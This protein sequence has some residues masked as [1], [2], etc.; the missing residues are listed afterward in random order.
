M[1]KVLWTVQAK[2]RVCH[3]S[4]RQ[5]CQVVCPPQNG[6]AVPPQSALAAML[7]P[8]DAVLELTFDKAECILVHDQLQGFRAKDGLHVLLVEPF[9]PESLGTYIVKVGPAEK[10]RLELENWS[11][12]RPLG[13][14]HDPVFLPL[15]KGAEET[16]AQAAGRQP[17]MSLI[18]GDA[19]QLIGV[20]QISTLEDAVLRS[21]RFGMPTVQSIG[22]VLVELLERLGHILYGRSFVDDPALRAD[23]KFYLP[24][25]TE[26][27]DLWDRDSRLTMVRRAASLAK[28]GAENFVDPVDCLRFIE[29]HLEPSPASPPGR[30]CA[31]GLCWS[32]SRPAVALAAPAGPAPAAFADPAEFLPRMLRGAAHGDL[33]GRN[34]L[35]GVM[36]ERALWPALFDYED[37]GFCKLVAWDFVKL[38]TE[39]KTRAYAE[40]FAGAR[41]PNATEHE[42]SADDLRIEGY[43]NYN[44]LMAVQQSEL[45]LNETT[46]SCY[47]RGRWPPVTRRDAPRDRLHGIL[48]EIRRMAQVHLGI[49]RGRPNDWLEE[50]YF[51]LACYGLCTA[52]FT[53]LTLRQWLGAYLS[54]G[55]AAAR[56]S[57]LRRQ[58]RDDQGR[59]GL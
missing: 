41:E 46:E 51:A 36:R 59:M 2:N 48:L 53:N 56:L 7:R 32:Q 5:F 39:L 13:M 44:F 49:D 30:P 12:C 31:A 19:H 20:R 17:L 40:I 6:T 45:K 43:E 18:Y 15:N 8:L 27:M 57:W 11:L 29:R 9:G 16:P 54:A 42:E 34:V 25:L 21:V 35:V 33:H 55:V 23:Y 28:L 58:Y 50:Y 52:R 10:L 26:C 22:M 1:A 47:R 14:S 37:M 3:A 24:H 38:E 4:A